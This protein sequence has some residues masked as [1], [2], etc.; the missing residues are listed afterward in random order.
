MSKFGLDLSAAVRLLSQEQYGDWYRDPWGWP[1]LTE[2]VTNSLDVDELVSS[3]RGS[4]PALRTPPHFQLMQIPK[5]RLGVRPAVIMDPVSRLFFTSAASAAMTDLH[6]DLPDWV[7]GWRQRGDG[8]AINSD[9]WR[10]YTS[11]LPATDSDSTK[12]HGLLTDITSFFASIKPRLLEDVLQVKEGHSAA[13]TSIPVQVVK[14]H[15]DLL[16]R[17][18]LPQRSFASAIYAHAILRPFDDTLRA[19]EDR[20]IVV[21]RWMDDVSAEGS[22]GDLYQLLLELHQAARQLGLELNASKTHL[23]SIEESANTLAIND[24]FRLD[25]PRIEVHNEYTGETLVGFDTELLEELEDKIVANP[26]KASRTVAS[27][28]LVGLRE[29]SM[30]DRAT[31][32]M[33]IAHY[34][35]HV[36]D[37]V[38]RYFRG[39]A[40]VHAEDGAWEHLSDWFY[41]YAHSSWGKLAWGTNQYALALP[42][43][44]QNDDVQKLFEQWLDSDDVQ[45]LAIAVQ[46]VGRSNPL[47]LK[48]AVRR[49][50]DATADPLLHRL[51][52]LGILG[53]GEGSHLPR[54][55]LARDPR[56]RLLLARLDADHWEPIVAV[57]DFDT[58]ETDHPEQA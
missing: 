52:A 7:Y 15:N 39:W 16:G 51:F 11:T 32:W 12:T 27:A 58:R 30:F 53:L 57:E 13:A 29:Q 46:R 49:R 4:P 37:R 42:S 2:Q 50:A 3:G 23:Q 8:M 44:T 25:L 24:T 38:G 48:N 9:E 43:G 45:Q 10:A 5:S 14:S 55:I 35:P 34:L 22:E 17:S 41:H 36:S 1:E 18:G 33:D 20:G 47:A 56:N 54:S 31:D 40:E 19:A 26:L 6:G 28:V 21:R